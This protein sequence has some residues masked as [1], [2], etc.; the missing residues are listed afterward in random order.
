MPGFNLNTVTLSGGLTADPELRSLPS[1][2]SVCRLR[3][4]YTER[5]KNNATGEWDDRSN[6]IDVTVWAGMGEWCARELS[7]GSQIVVTG[8]LRWHDWEA[9]DG[10]GKREKTDIVADS[11]FRDRGG[12]GGGRPAESFGPEP[13][14]VDRGGGFSARSDVPTDGG[15]FTPRQTASAAAGSPP[16]DDDIPF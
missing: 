4:A 11:I 15:G 6:Y 2:M 9:S 13:S 12:S 10:S 3:L 7:K 1:G 14:Q 8:R 5:V 16:P